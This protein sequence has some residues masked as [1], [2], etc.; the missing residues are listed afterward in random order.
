MSIPFNTFFLSVSDSTRLGSPLFGRELA[1]RL[2]QGDLAG[3]LGRLGPGRATPANVDGVPVLAGGLRDVGHS[4]F[5]LL[6]GAGPN[7][8]SFCV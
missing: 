6:L 5:F 4:F 8:F 7:A 3:R 1:G 2:H